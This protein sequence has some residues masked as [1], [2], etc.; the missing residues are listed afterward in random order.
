MSP[1]VCLLVP[2]YFMEYACVIQKLDPLF[3][4]TL[5]RSM[6]RQSRLS[7]PHPTLR[8]PPPP[9]G[10][11]HGLL[12]RWAGGPRGSTWSAYSRHLPSPLPASSSRRAPAPGV[13]EDLLWGQFPGAPVLLVQAGEGRGGQGVLDVPGPHAARLPQP[14]HHPGPSGDC[15]AGPL[16]RARRGRPEGP[17]A[18]GAGHDGA[19][20]PA[21]R[22]WGPRGQAAPR[23]GQPALP[24]RA[25]APDSHQAPAQEAPNGQ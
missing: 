11:G 1:T 13:P 12:A 10:E 17:A 8:P 25:R 22:P 16:P 3:K 15:H 18:A 7:P 6:A 24:Q 5:S 23:R 14:G 9:P 21:G 4:Q 2:F 20:G 19:A